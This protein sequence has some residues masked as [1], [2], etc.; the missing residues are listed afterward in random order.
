MIEAKPRRDQRLSKTVVV[1]V[2]AVTLSCSLGGL[3]LC[4]QSVQRAL[5]GEFDALIL[6]HQVPHFYFYFYPM[7]FITITCC[8]VLA[9]CGFDQLRARLS[10]LITFVSLLIFE[11]LYLFIIGGFVW[12]LSSNPMD[13]AAA[14]GVANQGLMAQVMVLLPIWAPIVLWRAKRYL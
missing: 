10:H 7:L 14:S 6:Q 4:W 13:V 12:R 3:F 9:W 5:N 1:M 8:L 11:V 2:G